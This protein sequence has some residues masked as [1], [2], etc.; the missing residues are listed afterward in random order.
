MKKLILLSILLA[1]CANQWWENEPFYTIGDWQT[2]ILKIPHERVGAFENVKGPYLP[3]RWKR[4][5]WKRGDG[6]LTREVEGADAVQTWDAQ[7][8]FNF[9]SWK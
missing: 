9:G 3:D 6:R 2:G 8:G 5:G 1:G 4:R 7:N